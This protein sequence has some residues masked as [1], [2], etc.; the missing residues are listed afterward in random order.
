[1]S[2]FGLTNCKTCDREFET[3]ITDGSYDIEG[4]TKRESWPD[5]DECDFCEGDGTCSEEGCTQQATVLDTDAQV[6]YC[7]AH[8]GECC[9]ENGDTVEECEEYV[10]RLDE[11][12][13]AKP[14][15]V[16]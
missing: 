2:G 10:L 4:Y 14:K 8:W 11:Q 1:M 15:E 3:S 9:K 7:A 13:H 16:K 5:E 6:V 12:L